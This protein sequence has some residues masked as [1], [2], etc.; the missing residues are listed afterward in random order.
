MQFICHG[1]V[2]R[3]PYAEYAFRRAMGD[4]VK[5]SSA[6]FIGPDRPSPEEGVRAASR[7]G[8]DLKPHRSQLMNT[9]TLRNTS[10]LVVMDAM[11]RRAVAALAGRP[12]HDV[13]ILGDLDPRRITRR[14]IRDPWGQPEEVFDEVYVRI[15]RCVAELARLLKR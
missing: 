14:G 6:G 8:I 13:V 10:V 4:A 11:Q 9:G 7:L 2:C 15:D 3:S 5:A 12:R 1:N